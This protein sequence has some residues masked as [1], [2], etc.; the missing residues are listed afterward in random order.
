MQPTI[1]DYF[2]YATLAG[3]AYV[4][5]GVAKPTASAF[6]AEAADRDTNRIASPLAQYLFAP[7]PAFPNPSPW[8][9]LH[10]YGN[11]I[12][13]VIDISGFGATLFDNG[14]D[15]VLALRGTEFGVDTRADL[16]QAS[17]AGIG[18]LGMALPQAVSM[19]NLILRLRADPNDTQVPQLHLVTASTPISDRSIAIATNLLR[20]SFVYID[21]YRSYDGQG[22]GG[23]APGEKITVTGHSLGGHLA[24]LA[25]RLFPDLV[26][27]A[28]AYNSPGFDPLLASDLTSSLQCAGSF[29]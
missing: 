7:T 21:F 2:K 22:V 11:D 23:I 29:A 26:D 6:A 28:F 5:A 27:A 4:R 24:V 16:L 15:K 13:G 1:F 20:T 9:I 18:L 8:Q 14:D 25:A 19:V 3:A 12:P 17:F 10:Y